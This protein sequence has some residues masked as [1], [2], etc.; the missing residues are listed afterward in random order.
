[1]TPV[2]RI[3]AELLSDLLR[4]IMVGVKSLQSFSQVSCHILCLLFKSERDVGG[5]GEQICQQSEGAEWKCYRGG[6][7]QPEQAEEMK[8]PS[9]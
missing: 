3:T 8:L 2:H 1:M 5:R 7:Y 9:V 4:T 6:S